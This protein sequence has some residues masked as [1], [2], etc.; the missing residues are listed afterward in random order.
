MS[1][2]KLNI[3]SLQQKADILERLKKGASV[4]ALSKQYNVAKSTI[5][6]FKKKESLIM[7]HVSNTFSGPAKK[8]TMKKA[9]FPRMEKRLYKWFMRMRS[10]NWPV[11][12]IMLKEK[13][14]Q[15]QSE[16][17]GNEAKFT[18][19]TGWLVKFKRRYGIRLLKVT[20]EKLSSQPELV[21][22]FK[23]K[24]KEKIDEMQLSKDQLYNADESG[25]YWKLL[26]E[27]SYVSASEKTAPGTKTEK[28][29][30]TFLCCANASGRHR[31]KLLVIGKAKKPRSFKDFNCPTDYTNSK[32]SWMTTTI[33]L[34]WFHNAFVPQVMT[35]NFS[36]CKKFLKFELF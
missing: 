18:A 29:R 15:L 25:L 30:I 7:K 9:E 32:S 22:P 10:K 27:K 4:T 17:Y 28:Q 13:A 12:G 5:C 6:S 3:L 20:G 33:F 16:I 21:D 2:K 23:I 14:K 11:S 35:E 8:K 24:L 34:R 19:S 1:S 31:L 26:P 36:R